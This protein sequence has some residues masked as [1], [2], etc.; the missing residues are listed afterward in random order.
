MKHNAS[1]PSLLTIADLS[2]R[3]GLPESTTRYYCKRFAQHLPYVGE[4]RKRRYRPEA[5]DILTAIAEG[6]RQNKNAL[7]V[8]FALQAS[9]A[10][11]PAKRPPS[12]PD[13]L[14]LKPDAGEKIM[15]FMERQTEALRQIADA[16]NML[17][18]SKAHETVLISAGEEVENLRGEVDA[19]RKELQNKEE[20][21][22]QKME[23]LRSWLARFSEA[24]AR[25]PI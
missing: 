18:A 25:R 21:Y 10:S 7:A 17:A 2:K 20:K 5:V 22:Q 8:D 11:L 13:F 12:E 1:A 19:L 14:Q 6:M 24:M 15:L 4:G 3:L 16:M 23:Q 9:A